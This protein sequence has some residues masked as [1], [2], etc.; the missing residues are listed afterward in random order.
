VS[1]KA[2]AWFATFLCVLAL[3]FSVVPV[4]R[5]GSVLPG[6]FFAFLPVVFF[7]IARQ[8]KSSSLAIR[9]LEARV[10]ELEASSTSSRRLVS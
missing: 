10:M 6:V 7:S 3:V 4:L 8:E 2:T 9:K 1:L 5:E